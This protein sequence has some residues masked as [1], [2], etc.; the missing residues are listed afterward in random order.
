MPP[1]RAIAMRTYDFEILVE[2]EGTAGDEF[3]DRYEDRLFELFSGDVYP[4][5]RSGAPYVNCTIEA[6]TLDEAV[7]RVL[8]ELNHEGLKATRV[9]FYPEAVIEAA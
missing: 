5:V 6:R 4:A 8:G 9:E 7:I 1:S 2:W 3:L